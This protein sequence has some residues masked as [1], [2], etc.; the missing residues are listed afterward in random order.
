MKKSKYLLVLPLA[1][2]TLAACNSGERFA[3][4]NYDNACKIAENYVES[5]KAN[6]AAT[7]EVGGHI[8]KL[9]VN[10]DMT[11]WSASYEK[12]KELGIAKTLLSLI[13]NFSIEDSELTINSQDI[14][15]FSIPGS[16]MDVVETLSGLKNKSSIRYVLLDNL[17]KFPMNT[18]MLQLINGFKMVPPE[19]EA[20]IEIPWEHMEDDP[21]DRADVN[22][23]TS[24]GRL[25]ITLE[26]DDIKGFGDEIEARLQGK[27]PQPVPPERTTYPAS[28]SLTTNNV[29]YIDSVSAK[30]KI[31]GIDEELKSK[32]ELFYLYINGDIELDLTL[33]FKQTFADQVSL[34]YQLVEYEEAE[35]GSYYVEYGDMKLK[36]KK[37]H[38]ITSDID[39]LKDYVT[40]DWYTNYNGNSREMVENY[41]DP[42]FNIN[43]WH[44]ED[45][46]KNTAFTAESYDVMI[47]PAYDTTGEKPVQKYQILGAVHTWTEEGTVVT[48]SLNSTSKNGR[49]ISNN[50]GIYNGLLKALESAADIVVPSVILEKDESDIPTVEV[51]A[52]ELYINPNM[53]KADGSEYIVSIAVLDLQ[54][55]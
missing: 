46:A 34:K 29:G 35:E 52:D 20:N 39:S 40:F 24:N 37:V 19:S 25:K 9:S 4:S 44:D 18:K 5:I 12:T 50:Q 1:L 45:C 42:I 27:D 32:D 51:D 38:D 15:K 16:L 10:G 23:Y 13:P 22:F 17:P 49:I 55:E 36:C 41:D 54:A 43:Y 7:I 48:P 28:F 11:W 26:T 21:W 47:F 8:N 6:K 2:T 31:E 3:K 33:N 14:A 53:L 30:L